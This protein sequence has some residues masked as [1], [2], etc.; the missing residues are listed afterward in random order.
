MNMK[1]FKISTIIIAAGLFLSLVV[2]LL[3]NIIQTPTI[4]EHQFNY[5]VTYKLCGEV[6][7]IEGVYKCRLEG[8]SE[9]ENPRD[10]YYTGE[11]VV[12]GKTFLSHSYTIAEKDGAELYIVTLFNDGYLMD[13]TGAMYYEP[14][15]EEPH[16]EAVDKEGYPY[17]ETTMP[18]EFEAEIIS[19]DYPEPIENSLVF[20]GF[21]ILHVGSMLAMLAVG[22]LTIVACLACVKKDKTA[23]TKVLDILSVVANFANCIV[24]IPFITICTAFFQLTMS[25]DDILY[26]IFLCIPA[27]T[28][29]TVAASIAL[30]RRGF[31]KTGFLVQFVGSVI[32]FVPFVIESIMVN[33][34]G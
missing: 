24:I 25:T 9:G 16:L 18:A 15:L 23:P 7:T 14:F 22:L 34:F 8:Y 29:F 31:T 2:C 4:T 17:D 19:W 11:Y 32:F 3:T 1:N 5:S 33:F 26:Q 28:A 6:K 12:D 30:R 21:S 13:D 27:L 10:R 20:V